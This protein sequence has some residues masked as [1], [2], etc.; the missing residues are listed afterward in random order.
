M[1]VA[2][3]VGENLCFDADDNEVIVLW[4][5]GRQVLPKLSKQELARQLVDVVAARYR[6]AQAETT[7]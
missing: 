1:I 6:L 2:N 7:N 3:L 5:E 4:Q